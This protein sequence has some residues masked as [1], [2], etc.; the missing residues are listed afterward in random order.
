LTR[1]TWKLR[2]SVCDSNHN[3]VVAI[4][5]AGSFVS[6]VLLT[7]VEVSTQAMEA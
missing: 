2:G 1:T 3:G 5:M 4:S 6:A 7:T